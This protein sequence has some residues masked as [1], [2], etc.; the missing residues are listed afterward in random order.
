MSGKGI[1]TLRNVNRGYEENVTVNLI[2]GSIISQSFEPRISLQRGHG[3]TKNS[4]F[5]SERNR[6]GEVNW[7]NKWNESAKI[8]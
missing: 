5:Y 1:S 6:K 4:L 3:I 2:F 8:K 7:D